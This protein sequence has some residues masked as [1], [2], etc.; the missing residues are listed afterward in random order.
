MKALSVQQ[1]WAQLLLNGD[2]TIEVR[3]WKTPHRGPLLICASAAPKAVFFKVQDDPALQLYAGTMIGIV[4]LVDCRPMVEAD[5]EA[6]FGN[7]SPGAFAWVIK[8]VCFVRPDP[9]KGALSLFNVPDE[10]IARLDLENNDFW[11]YDLPLGV[12]E[13]DPKKHQCI[14]FS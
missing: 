4:D 2:K 9:L 10:K 13:F 8:P 12:V 11:D 14:H 3:S 5:D 6:S 1:P 7:Y